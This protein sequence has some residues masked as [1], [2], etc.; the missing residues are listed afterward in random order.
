MV[1]SSEQLGVLVSSELLASGGG[2]DR[3]SHMWPGRPGRRVCP[4]LCRRAYRQ[5][6]VGGLEH[7]LFFHIL[8]I[9]I[10]IDFHIFQ[11]CWNHQPDIDNDVFH[12]KGT[13]RGNDLNPEV[14][15]TAG[16]W[17]GSSFY[18][19]ELGRTDF[20]QRGWNHQPDLEVCVLVIGVTMLR[21][22]VE[23]IVNQRGLLSGV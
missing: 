18:C 20:F 1:D 6:L 14:I 4:A 8:G 7:F 10:P 16:R 3:Q 22:V 13:R 2:D 21:I 11:R 17:F 12:W 5:W 23:R 9:I 19:I 15:W